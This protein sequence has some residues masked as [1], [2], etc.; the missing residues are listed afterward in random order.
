M[1]DKQSTKTHSNRLSS[2]AVVALWSLWA[3]SV[4]PLAVLLGEFGVSLGECERAAWYY[5][6]LYGHFFVFPIT[7]GLLAVVF[8][9]TPWICTVNT[10]RGLPSPRR[11]RVITFLGASIVVI[12]AFASWAEFAKATPAIWSF[13]AAATNFPTASRSEESADVIHKGLAA[14]AKRCGC[15]TQ[16]CRQGKDAPANGKPAM[17]PPLSE[18]QYFEG[19][20]SYT[21]WAYYVGFIANTTWMALLFGVVV[22]RAGHS[23]RSQGGL[24]LAAMALATAWVPFRASFLWEKQQLYEADPLLPLNF[25]IFLAFIV[26]HMHMFRLHVLRLDDRKQQVV[27]GAGNLIVGVLA[28]LSASIGSLAKSNTGWLADGGHHLVSWFGS[29]SSLLVY[30]TMLLLV[31]VMIAPD[32]IRRLLRGDDGGQGIRSASRGGSSTCNDAE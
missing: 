23:D 30:I 13:K 20:R 28:L 4:L 22:M 1:D 31:L 3:L 7:F 26:L 17:K 19:E 8:L 6:K 5:A 14:L 25:L 27:L 21:E 11:G 12:V 18:L 16:E 2:I 9:T 32:V 15:E 24:T 29:Q 10:I